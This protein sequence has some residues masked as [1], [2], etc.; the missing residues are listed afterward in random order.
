M[1]DN[2]TEAPDEWYDEL[3]KLNTKRISS[4]FNP[5]QVPDAPFKK[6]WPELAM[7]RTIRQAVEEG[8]SRVSWT[9]GEAQAARYD[10]SKSST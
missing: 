9:P 1:Q 6:S 2:V 3:E 4:N 5:Y 8:K 10:L 7:K